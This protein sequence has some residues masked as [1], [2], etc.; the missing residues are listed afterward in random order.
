[1]KNNDTPSAEQKHKFLVVA[2]STEY[3]YAKIMA[4]DNVEAWKFA[5]DLPQGCF[6]VTQEDW[7]VEKVRSLDSES[8]S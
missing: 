6:E 8:D 5:N 1:M 2:R 3:C 7:T 4:R